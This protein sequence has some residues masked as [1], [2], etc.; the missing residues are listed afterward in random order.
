MNSRGRTPRMA[1]FLL[2]R[3][4]EHLLEVPVRDGRTLIGRGDNCD[5]LVPGDSVSRTH[6]VITAQD[7]AFQVQDRSRHGTFLNGERLTRRSPLAI[8][9]RLQIGGFALQLSDA[10]EQ[11]ATVSTRA[12]GRPAQELLSTEAARVLVLVIT[13]GPGQG[14]RIPITRTRTMLGSSGL[15]LG[16]DQLQARHAEL[17]IVRGRPLLKPLDGAVFVDAERVQSALPVYVNEPIR[18]GRTHFRL[19]HE[20]DTSI[21]EANR[22]GDMVGESEVMRQTFGMLRRMA[23]HNAP[24]LLLGESGTGKELAARGLHQESP[25][26]PARFVAVNC[27]AIA[28]NL[29]ES[30]LFG[31]VKGSFTGATQTYQGAFERADGG[32]L[33]LDEVGELPEPAQAKL[34]RALESG[35][36]RKVG[37]SEVTYPDVRVVAATNRNLQEAVAEGSFRADLFFRLAVLAVRLPPLRERPEDLA[38]LARTLAKRLG[39]DVWISDEAIKLLQQ[40]EFPGNGRELR[41]VLTRAYVLG[42]SLI[43]P[44]TL[45]FSP[46][47]YEL[48]PDTSPDRLE[49]AEKRVLLEALTRARGNRSKVARELGIARSTLHYKLQRFGLLDD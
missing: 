15:D 42:G 16:D 8:G 18:V 39:N 22:F 36:I 38:S 24:V 19:E 3:G 23:A 28:E 49:D 31:H 37:G 47:S 40:H 27:G 41:N 2:Y 10:V 32:T 26:A 12:S 25:R 46:W 30:E 29:F 14:R 20:L 44:Q 17:Q 4:D 13:E 34:L 33:F 6:C 7:G 5:V 48:R 43:T 45:S 1:R 11:G 21:P 35:E 9:D